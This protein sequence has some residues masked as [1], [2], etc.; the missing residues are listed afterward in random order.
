MDEPCNSCIEKLTEDQFIEIV[1][2]LAF[3]DDAINRE[4]SRE[5]VL[6]RL[7]KFSDDAFK[8]NEAQ[9]E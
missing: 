5:E 1:Y 3:G 8:Y 7:R 9:G 2:E 4:F 6:Q